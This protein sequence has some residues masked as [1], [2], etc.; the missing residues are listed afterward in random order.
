MGK[1]ILKA[2]EALN[3]AQTQGF[4]FLKNQIAKHIKQAAERGETSLT[5]DFSCV[6]DATIRGKIY[7][8]FMDLDYSLIVTGTDGK[9][10][11]EIE[12]KWGKEK[13]EDEG[14][15]CAYGFI[16]YE[17]KTSGFQNAAIYILNEIHS[18]ARKGLIKAYINIKDMSPKVLERVL[19]P[20]RE[21]GFQLEEGE[22]TLTI[23]W[24]K[25]LEEIVQE[26]KKKED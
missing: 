10:V 23:S 21:T 16:D 24:T 11:T 26:S 8:F 18:A 25:P 1:E 5:W 2:D 20:Y 19:K 3:V 15:D 22:D 4:E 17:T 6:D 12:F 13:E 7:R 9:Q 14:C